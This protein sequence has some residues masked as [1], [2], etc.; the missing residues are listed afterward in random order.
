MTSDWSVP[1]ASWTVTLYYCA[2][3]GTVATVAAAAARTAVTPQSRTSLV[4]GNRAIGWSA[5]HLTC[6][7]A[8]P[9]R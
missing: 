7:A 6:S 3:A 8:L 2:E 9:G 5:G 1:S 4:N